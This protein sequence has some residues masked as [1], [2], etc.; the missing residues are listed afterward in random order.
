MKKED[1]KNSNVITNIQKDLPEVFKDHY[2]PIDVMKKNTSYKMVISKRTDGK[3][4]AFKLLI[5]YAFQKFDYNS[6]IVRRLDSMIKANMV[7]HDF[8][9]IFERYPA[10]NYK[11]YDG[12][13][14]YMGGHRGYWLDEKGKKSFDKPFIEYLSVNTYETTKSSKDYQN[15]YLILFDEII[16]RNK[17]IPDEFIMWCNLLSTI[18]RETTDCIICMLGNPVSWVSP[19]FT[20]YGVDPLLLPDNT[21]TVFKSGKSQT[22]IAI[23]KVGKLNGNK[24]IDTVNDRYFGFE[25]HKVQSITSGIWETPMYPRLKKLPLEEKLTDK[26]FCRMNNITLRLEICT[27][28]SVGLFVRVHQ[29]YFDDFYSDDIIFDISDEPLLQN[30]VYFRAAQYNQSIAKIINLLMY[31]Y[32]QQKYFYS[33][34]TV[35]ESMRLFWLEFTDNKPKQ[36]Y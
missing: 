27:E 32:K 12:I 17:Y 5:Y 19:Y 4:Y 24:K 36:L 25:N 7:R 23:E 34:N 2:N 6:V 30:N 29:F 10:I 9:V 33:D 28:K 15:L 26:L 20:N 35:G 16:S 18:I 11:N 1:I 8:D 22:S 14:Y 31:L 13:A 21:I 3:S